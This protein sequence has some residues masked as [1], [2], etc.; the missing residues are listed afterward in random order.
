MSIYRKDWVITVGVFVGLLVV[1]LGTLLAFDVLLNV[2]HT[3]GQVRET[4]KQNL[5]ILQ[6]VQRETDLQAAGAAERKQVLDQLQLVLAAAKAAGPTLSAG[7]QQLIADLGAICS[8]T[9]GCV[10]PPATTTP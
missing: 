3:V 5:A 7:Q 9:P 8:A 4:Q 2:H 10:L 1:V 6:A